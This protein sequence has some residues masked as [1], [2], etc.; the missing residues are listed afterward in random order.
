MWSQGG[1]SLVTSTTS[2]EF[3]SSRGAE[4]GCYLSGDCPSKAAPGVVV[5]DVRVVGGGWRSGRGL[6]WP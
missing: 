1:E 4:R 3:G 2:E 5:V 6:P